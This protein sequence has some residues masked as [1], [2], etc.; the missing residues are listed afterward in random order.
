MSRARKSLV[1]SPNVSNRQ[2][3]AFVV[4]IRGASLS[5]SVAR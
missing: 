1:D 5:G 3:D 4:G 2:R